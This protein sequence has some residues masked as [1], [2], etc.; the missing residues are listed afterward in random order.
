MIALMSATAMPAPETFTFSIDP[1][2][3]AVIPPTY[4]LFVALLTAIDVSTFT[5]K[6]FPL[7]IAEIPAIFAS[8]IFEL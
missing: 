8:A 6:I 4:K 2:F 1:K 5:F 3:V 7:L